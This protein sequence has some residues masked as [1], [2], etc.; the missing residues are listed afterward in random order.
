MSLHSNRADFSNI[1]AVEF[2]WTRDRVVE[3]ADGAWVVEPVRPGSDW[4]VCDGHR[5]RHT[6]WVRVRPWGRR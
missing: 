2:C 1:V 5:E 6:R 4:T 3:L